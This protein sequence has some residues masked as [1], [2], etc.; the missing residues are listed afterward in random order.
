MLSGVN[1]NAAY[2]HTKRLYTGLDDRMSTMGAL[3]DYVLAVCSAATRLN[4]GDTTDSAEIIE[5]GEFQINL[6]TRIVRL[7]GRELDLTSAEFDL[8]VFLVDHPKQLIT[9]HTRLATNWSNSAVRQ[10]EFLRTLMSLR[11]KLESGD[12]AHCYI[13]TEPWF[14]YRFDATASGHQ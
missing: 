10:T 8:L 4:R 3:K 2:G 6:I 9:P 12:S 1:V 11:K 5:A 7:R 14:F 13:R